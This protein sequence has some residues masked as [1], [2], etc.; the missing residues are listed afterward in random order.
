MKM[1][2]AIVTGG[3]GGEAEISLKSATEIARELQYRYD[4]SIVLIQNYKW[5]AKGEK[6]YLE[7]N[8]NRFDAEYRGLNMSYS[9]VY[10]AMH[11][12]PGEDGRLQG[13]FE[14]LG[15]PY[16]GCDVLT[17]ALAFNKQACKKY[18]E[19]FGV[20]SAAGV[21][22]RRD[23][24]VDAQSIIAT[25]GLP[26]FVKPNNSG[27]S[28]GITKV[29]SIEELNPAIEAAFAEGSEVLVEQFIQGREITCGLV[30]DRGEE[31]IFPLA[32]I[33]S[34]NEFFDYEAKYN[35]SLADEI[36]PAP[37]PETIAQECRRLSSHIYDVMNCFGIVR[38]DYIF[39]ETGLYFLEI[40]TIP[41]QTA[42]SIVPKMAKAMGLSLTD[43]YENEVLSAIARFDNRKFFGKR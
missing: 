30:K 33:V 1:S 5:Y 34:K 13:Y 2:L 26:C 42:E 14:T 6:G 23:Q 24:A 20:R 15:I 41:G 29:K 31:I 8:K 16:T 3:H 40:N 17:S 39:N 32:E 38:I 18:L 43:L 9:C 35:P 4:V 27:S 19:S 21:L 11:G 10:I 7:V 37:V 36:I 22:I 12:S 28:C 25:T